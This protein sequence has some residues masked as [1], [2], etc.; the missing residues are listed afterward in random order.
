[1]LFLSI[2]P[3]LLIV[4]TWLKSKKHVRRLPLASTIVAMLLYIPGMYL[5]LVALGA[6]FYK[7][8]LLAWRVVGR[9]SKIISCLLFV[10]L[11][12]PLI[13]S[14]IVHPTQI[15]EWLGLN[16]LDKFL[17]P[18][19]L[20][21]LKDIPWQLFVNGPDD[22]SKWLV[23][24]PI[25]DIF[26]TAMLIIG[27]N[28]YRR[29]R[30]PL[31]A[32]ILLGFFIG[33]ILLIS[34]GGYITVALLLPLIYIVVANGITNMLQYWFTVF[35]RNPFARNVGVFLLSIVILFAAGYHTKRYFIAWPNAPATKQAFQAPL[36]Q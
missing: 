23:G 3:L 8:L 19:L 21:N 28:A 33:S 20:S 32:R 2:F 30:H 5:F 35:P 27:I 31:R 26:T 4:G 10:F 1:V 24:S 15:I 9:Q 36:E 25:I 7:R 34:L 14:F 12:I 11:L 6:I 13:Y 16:S 18:A 17:M 22:P 29:G